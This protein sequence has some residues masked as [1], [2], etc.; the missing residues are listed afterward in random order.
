[1]FVFT[2]DQIVNT[3][4]NLFLGGNVIFTKETQDFV[5]TTNTI[6]ISP[7]ITLRIVFMPKLPI[8]LNVDFYITNDKQAVHRNSIKHKLRVTSTISI[9]SLY[10][11][12]HFPLSLG[13]WYS[14]MG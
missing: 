4:F 2:I 9:N 8:I 14:S 11:S 5:S 3:L 12:N 1:M 6:E 10:G 7:L 13:C